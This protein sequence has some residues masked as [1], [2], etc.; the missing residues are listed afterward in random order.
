MANVAYKFYSSAE[1]SALVAEV[2]RLYRAGGRTYVS[3]AR[4]L[5][6]RD[7]SYHNWLSQGIRPA[8]VPALL[9]AQR[10]FTPAERENFVAEIDRLRG[11]GHTLKAACHEADISIRSYRKWKE[12]ASPSLPMR[13]VEVTA[14]VPT[15]ATALALVP[16]TGAWRRSP[17]GHR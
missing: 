1:K 8:T 17:A 10:V 15:V 3:I 11:R 13:T 9:V 7:S 6:I 4:E 16:P 12:A 14:L 5:G 2:E